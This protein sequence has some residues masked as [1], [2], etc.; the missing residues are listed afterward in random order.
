[1]LT[2]PAIGAALVAAIAGL[3]IAIV[4][5]IPHVGRLQRLERVVAILEKVD[6]DEARAS[7][8]ELRNRMIDRLSPD[9]NVWMRLSFIGLG[10][11]LFGGLINLAEQPLT[12]AG[13]P[14]VVRQGTVVVSGALAILFSLTGM[15]GGVVALRR[16]NASR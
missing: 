3:V 8:I 12:E 4:G 1:M 16:L 2:E 6:D 14:L 13:V 7:L 10:F 9:R 11:A 15:I 5:L